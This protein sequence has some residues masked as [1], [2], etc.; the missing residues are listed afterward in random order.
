MTREEFLRRE[1]L[2]RI[3]RVVDHIYAHHGDELTID[4]LADIAAF[5][6]FHFHRVFSSITGETVSDF[7]KRVRLQQAASRLTEHPGEAVTDVALAVGFSSPSVFARAFRSRFGVTAS[8]WRTLDGS[9]RR[10]LAESN[11]CTVHSTA[12]PAIGNPGQAQASADRYDLSMR[13]DDSRRDAMKSL[14]YKVEVR[15]LPELTVA[16]ARHVGAFNAIGEAFGRLSRWAGPR[17][18]FRVPG[19]Q[20]LAVYHDSPETTP[21]QKLRSS[22][23]VTVAPGTEVSGDI[24]VMTIPGGMFAVARFEILPSQFGEAW[25]A[26]MGEW[27]PSSG[28]QP[29]D[30]MCYEVYLQDPASH[31]KGM[32]VIDI[33]EPVRPL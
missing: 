1:Y 23:C 4:E 31:P 18:L 15:K 29:D 8:V 24:N 2:G 17:G 22:A 10:L 16:Y 6:R 28:Y 25:D 19:A 12:G 33:C 7:L 21:E 13:T 3:E 14:S 5:S 9:K 11:A 27:F 30:R 26:L 20:S 32:F